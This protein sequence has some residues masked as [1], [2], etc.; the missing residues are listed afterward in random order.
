MGYDIHIT[1]AAE[2]AQNKESEIT[3]K[4]WQDEI[5]ADPELVP[6]PENGPNAVLWKGHP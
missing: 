4:E 3:T 5:Q 2:W 1:R 6:D